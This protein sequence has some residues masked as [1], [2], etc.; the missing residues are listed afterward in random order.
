MIYRIARQNLF[1]DKVRLCVTLTGIVFAVVLIT[2]EI[3]LFLGF[4]Q[5]IS[6]VIDHS[7][8]DVWVTSRGVKNFDIALS[9]KERKYYEVISLPEVRE[10]AKFIIRFAD[11]KKPD[12]LQE[13]IEIIGYE[14]DK[15]MGGPWNFVRGSGRMLD[16]R[17]AIVIDQLYMEKLGVTQLGEQVEINKKKAR[18]AAL[19]QG[20][21]SF[22]TSPYVFASL[23][24]ARG[25]TFLEPG[26]FTYL[27]VRGKAGLPPERLKQA[28]AGRVDHVDV[29]TTPE[30]SAKTQRYW[31]FNTG[32]GTGL[33]I[34]AFLGLVVGMVIVA[35]TLYA[36]TLDHISE[37]ATLKA[38]GAP[39]AYIYSIIIVQ[40]AISALLGYALGILAASIISDMSAFSAM[41][42]VLPWGLK[43]AMLGL[44]MVMC[45]VSAVISIRKVMRLDPAL[46]FKGR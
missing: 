40:A 26:E 3:G 46:V 22:T 27:L 23:D 11:W 31:M 32:A 39:N 17:D 34:A 24:V 37:F 5:T 14:T 28:I 19:T 16:L 29:Y 45:I 15:D 1:H 7:G 6:A 8:A 20:I 41:V 42:I 21:R 35:Q 4:T 30:F 36:T 44:T 12:G 13:S 18:V 25:Y 33:L 38:M 10:A 9:L 43:L 2:V